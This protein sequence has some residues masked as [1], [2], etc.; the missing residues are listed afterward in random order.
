M[1]LLV[2]GC[3]KTYSQSWTQ[4]ANF[5][6][7]ARAYAVGFVVNGKGYIGT[8]GNQWSS[9][10]FWEYNTSSDSW[11]QTD[12]LPVA[13][14]DGVGF[15]INGKG[16]S[17]SGWGAYQLYWTFDPIANSWTA[18]ANFPGI[19]REDQVGF[20]INGKGY[21]GTGWTGTACTNEFW[22]YDPVSNN[23]TQKANVPGVPRNYAVGFSIGAKGYVGTGSSN[24]GLL[25]D[26][27]EYDPA[28][29]TWIQKANF[30]GGARNY[31]S[32]FTIDSLGYVGTGRNNTVDLN[33][34]WS[35][36]PSTDSW[37][38]IPSMPT[39]GRNKAVGF[40]IG[41]KGYIGTGRY[42]VST[43]TALNDFWE[44]S[45]NGITGVAESNLQ[46]I[47]LEAFPNPFDDI[48]IITLKGYEQYEIMLYDLHSRKLLHQAFRNSA[49]I[50]TE[51]LGEGIYI[52]KVSNDKG[53]ITTGKLIKQ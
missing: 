50:N 31:A 44:Y 19:G 9:K 30:A 40:S 35:Y 23:W 2:L 24:T 49:T 38:Q 41:Q 15:A 16:Y 37:S 12:S 25:N 17:G 51:Q 33:D 14:N 39:P 47:F 10:D 18:I 11:T 27:W 46:T 20:T 7:I 36:N 34:F 43:P 42:G 32:C 21:V 3:F 52:Y 8:G 6:G 13:T 45:P 28:L 22:E 5:G 26:F 4:K 1:I 53:I 29:D 48:L